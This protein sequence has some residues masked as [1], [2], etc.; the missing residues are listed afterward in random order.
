MK[1]MYTGVGGKT[2]FQEDIRLSCAR[3]VKEETGLEIS[4][5]TLRG[6]VKTL[7]E[8]KNS[9]WILFIF[10]ARALNDKFETCE[11]GT[12]EWVDK[13]EVP[14]CHLI[15]FIREIISFVLSEDLFVEGM[16]FHDFEGNVL[17]KTLTVSSRV[18]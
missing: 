2:E 10:V 13:D 16:I 11:E 1:D 8:E 12:L 17:N 6:V 15:P 18:C 9:S 4:E 7:F 3:E 5:L 14:S